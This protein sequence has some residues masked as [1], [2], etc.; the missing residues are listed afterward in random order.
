MEPAQ[1]VLQLAWA[2]AVGKLAF[3]WA[4]ATVTVLVWERPVE[5]WRTRTE[6][7][8]PAERPDSTGPVSARMLPEPSRQ[9]MA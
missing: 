6:Y 5:F 1:P 2:V 4:V 7:T 8:S 3:C 9:V